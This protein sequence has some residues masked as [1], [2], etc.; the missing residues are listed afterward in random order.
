MQTMT[1]SPLVS[2]GL[3]TFN[4]SAKLR[5]AIASALD[6]DYA[7]IELIISDNASTD[8]TAAICQDAAD[9]DGRVKYFRQKENVGITR[10]FQEVFKL[11]T[12]ELYMWSADDDW[13][14]PKFVSTCVSFFAQNPD[15]VLVC[16]TTKYFEG[17]QL[18]FEDTEIDLPQNSGI[19]R[20]IAYYRSVSHNGAMYGLMRRFALQQI[21]LQATLGGDW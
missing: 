15:H 5:R 17:E 14:D 4:R 11:G 21:S 3:P 9:R 6:Q 2:I 20:V 12:G 10:N 8:E 19:K 16:G 1:T 18:I 13:L 7:N